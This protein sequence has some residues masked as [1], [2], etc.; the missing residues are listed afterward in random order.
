MWEIP[1]GYTSEVIIIIPLNGNEIENLAIKAKT[2][3]TFKLF[4]GIKPIMNKAIPEISIPIKQ[5]YFLPNLL[6]IY[7]LE[8]PAII[9]NEV[10]IAKLWYGFPAKSPVFKLIP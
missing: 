5:G 1:V 10:E 7:W 4:N 6:K 8:M 9:S 3:I 2:V